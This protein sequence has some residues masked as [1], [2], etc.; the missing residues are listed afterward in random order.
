M[1][2]WS[3][4]LQ[5]HGWPTQGGGGAYAI[6]LYWDT[7]ARHSMAKSRVIPFLVMNDLYKEVIYAFMAHMQGHMA[8]A[9]A[10]LC[11]GMVHAQYTCARPQSGGLRKSKS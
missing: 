10:R 7:M 4:T 3:W 5:G 9:H 1:A 11:V 2:L 8:M 6:W